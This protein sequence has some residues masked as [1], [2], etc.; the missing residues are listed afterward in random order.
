MFFSE[1]DIF[2][3]D[4]RSMFELEALKYE[5][6]EPIPTPTTTRK[7]T[8]TTAKKFT[9]ESPPCCHFGKGAPMQNRAQV[10]R[11]DRLPIRNRACTTRLIVQSVSKT[12][13]LIRSK[14]API[15]NRVR[16]IRL[17]LSPMQTRKIRVR[18]KPECDRIIP[19][20]SPQPRPPLPRIPDAISRLIQNR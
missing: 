2:T 5:V 20:R 6:D 16:G 11:L 10:M 18:L 19:L 7:S 9:S 12:G 3:P 15:S 1:Y 13:G 4:I 17:S 14:A 8:A